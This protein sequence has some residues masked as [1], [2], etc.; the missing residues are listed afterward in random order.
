L[1]QT[2]IEEDGVGLAAIQVGRLHRIFA[3]LEGDTPCVYVNP[4]ISRRSIR[5]TTDAEGCL[6]LPGIV[7][8]VKRSRSCT[9]RALDADGHPVVRRVSGLIARIYQHEIDHLDGILFIDRAVK[10]ARTDERA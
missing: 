3:V 8:L 2:M 7:G 1:K 5:S 4:M 9:M 6:S 10:T